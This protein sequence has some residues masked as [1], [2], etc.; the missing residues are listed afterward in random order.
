MDTFGDRLKLVRGRLSQADFAALLGIPQVTLGNYERNRNEPRFEL[1]RKICLH[2]GIN[3][4]WLLFGSGSMHPGGEEKK[5][6]AQTRDVNEERRLADAERRALDAE[7]RTLSE[8]NRRLYQEKTALLEQNAD[9][10]ERVARL[11][12]ELRQ[13]GAAR[14]AAESG[15][16]A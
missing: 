1:I 8:E 9:L 12:G 13:P 7:R 6:G 10:R 5:D 16:V 2:F 11:E 3:A 4:E 14:P 15:A